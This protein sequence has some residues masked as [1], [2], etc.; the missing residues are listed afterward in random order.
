MPKNTKLAGEEETEVAEPGK[1]EGRVAR[2]KRA[3]S[4]AQHVQAFLGAHLNRDEHVRLGIGTG[5]ASG[6]EIRSGSTDGV[7]DNVG[8]EGGKSYGRE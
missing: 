5:L 7:L 3:P 1:R 8:E 4:I 2:W 6:N